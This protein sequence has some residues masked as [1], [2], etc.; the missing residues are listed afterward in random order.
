MP[1][2][3]AIFRDDRGDDRVDRGKQTRGEVGHLTGRT[4]KEA[5]ER[6]KDRNGTGGSSEGLSRIHLQVSNR[7]ASRAF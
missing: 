3:S 5:R 2:Y 6:E 7:S 4:L 1:R